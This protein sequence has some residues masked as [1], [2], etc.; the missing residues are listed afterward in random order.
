M[1][2]FKICRC[3]S[4]RL[5]WIELVDTNLLF[6]CV[7]NKIY[8]IEYQNE[9]KLCNVNVKY[10]ICKFIS[11]PFLYVKYWNKIETKYDVVVVWLTVPRSLWFPHPEMPY[12]NHSES[13]IKKK[14]KMQ[15]QTPYYSSMTLSALAV[16]PNM[17]RKQNIQGLFSTTD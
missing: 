4:K 16:C 17:G 8:Y 7:H 1:L 9:S 15:W 10:Y 5:K 11:I 2:L 14:Q 13:Q 6:Y 3:L 12:I